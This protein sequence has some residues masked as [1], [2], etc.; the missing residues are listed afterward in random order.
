M[1]KV[2]LYFFDYLDALSRDVKLNTTD[3]KTVV[4]EKVSTLEYRIFFWGVGRNKWGGGLENSRKFNKWL[5]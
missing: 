1:E 3:N 2:C 5:E 4:K